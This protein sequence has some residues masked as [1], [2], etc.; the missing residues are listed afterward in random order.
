MSQLIW[1]NKA[2]SPK[3]SLVQISQKN[4]YWTGSITKLVEL[5][6]IQTINLY[7]TVI[8]RHAMQLLRGCLWQMVS[9]FN[10]MQRINSTEQDKPFQ[11]L[12]CTHKRWHCRP[13]ASK[14]MHSWRKNIYLEH[15]NSLAH[16]LKII[17][18][19]VF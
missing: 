3:K 14:L 1:A 10:E 18:I 5:K 2:V 12:H 16:F 17:A 19:F 4:S 7:F 9:Q 11:F 13:E 6:E 15:G 8:K